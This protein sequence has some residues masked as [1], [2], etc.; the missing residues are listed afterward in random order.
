MSPQRRIPASQFADKIEAYIKLMQDLGRSFRC[1]ASLLRTFDAFCLERHYDGPLTQQLAL[2]FCC[3]TPSCGAL[4]HAK[5]YR[6]VRCFADYL[7]AFDPR[8]QLLDP[9]AVRVRAARPKA[10]IYTT[11]E[12]P[13]LLAAVGRVRGIDPARAAIYRT[14]L[15]LISCTGLRIREAVGLNVEDIDLATGVL[16]V[17]NTKFRKS[18]LVPLH[19]TTCQAV[20]QYLALRRTLAAAQDQ[21]AVFVNRRGRRLGYTTVHTVFCKLLEL[22]GI[23]PVGGRRPRVHD[24]RHTFAVR[25]VLAWYEAGEDV[26]AKLPLLATYMGHVHFEDTTYYLTAGAELIEKAAGRFES[27]RSMSHE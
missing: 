25:R 7:S 5:R 21:P 22:T 4:Q 15:G 10:Y 6:I 18:R 20:G 17:R 27:G 12:I 23:G 24:M 26:Q 1:E 9:R 19:A 11:E 8:T 16:R 3:A 2:E 13:R 14:L